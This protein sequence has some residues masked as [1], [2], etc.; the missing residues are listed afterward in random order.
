MG[1]KSKVI[2]GFLLI[3]FITSVTLCVLGA[4]GQATSLPLFKDLSQNSVFGQTSQYTITVVDSS[5][6]PR[7]ISG[8]QIYV[9]ND[10]DQDY[11]SYAGYTDQWGQKTYGAW[12]GTQ[13]EVSYNGVYTT[14]TFPNQPQSVYIVLPVTVNT[15]PPP[16]SPPI[17]QTT[18]SLIVDVAPARTGTVSIDD[19]NS[20]SQPTYPSGTSITIKAFPIIS[21]YVF[22][23]FVINGQTV[24]T[25]PYTF[26]ITKDTTITANFISTAPT[27]TMQPTPSPA[28]S[29]IIRLSMDNNAVSITVTNNQEVW[30]KI[31]TIPSLGAVE[32]DLEAYIGNQFISGHNFYT[33]A[34]TGLGLTNANPGIT[35]LP[36]GATELHWRVV[37]NGQASN[38]VTTKIGPNPTVTETLGPAYSS[39]PTLS[40]TIPPSPPINDV[41]SETAIVSGIIAIFSGLSLAWYLKK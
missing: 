14:A 22:S 20:Y 11:T 25:S 18:Y 33:D 9:W 27:P 34:A 26:T 28:P 10:Y 13:I 41:N 3:V 19:G 31:E 21:D 6:P 4:T 1:K 24:N 12:E 23:N 35:A 37:I 2:S 32:G 7:P 38:T 16:T 17:T 30:F 15:T 5:N 8:A 36:Y 40:P 29:Q 39:T